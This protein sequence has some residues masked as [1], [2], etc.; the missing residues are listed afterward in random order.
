M[1]IIIELGKAEGTVNKIN[2]CFIVLV[3]A[4]IVFSTLNKVPLIV[5]IA[6]TAFVCCCVF[7]IRRPYKY[8]VASVIW[9][10]AMPGKCFGLIDTLPEQL[11]LCEQSSK[12]TQFGCWL[13]FTREYENR[14]MRRL[15]GTARHWVF[16][17][18]TS[19]SLSDYKRLCRHII[20]HG[21]S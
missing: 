15:C 10:E 16:V 17:P 8:A 11:A 3:W 6:S 14:T 19:V 4:S 7:F 2:V 18:K 1:P 5:T 12:T 21:N 13:A 20:W 9:N